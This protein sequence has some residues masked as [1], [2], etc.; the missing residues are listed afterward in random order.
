MPI[1]YDNKFSYFPHIAKMVE[2]T[3]F[4]QEP[5]LGTS[6]DFLPRLNFFSD[7]QFPYLRNGNH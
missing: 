7:P 4:G 5:E 3:K 2:N 6:S 1:C